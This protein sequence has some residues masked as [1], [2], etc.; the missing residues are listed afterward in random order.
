MTPERDR[1]FESGPAHREHTRVSVA[2]VGYS[3]SGKTMSLLRFAAGMAEIQGGRTVVIDSNGRRSLHYAPKRGEQPARGQTFDFDVVHLTPPFGPESW[4][5]AF[6]HALRKYKAARIIVDCMSDEWEGQGGVLDAHE[7]LLDE[8]MDRKSKSGKPDSRPD[9][10]IREAL[11]DSAWIPVK[12]A[13][14]ELRLWMWQQPVDWLLTYRAKQKID[15]SSK[16]RKELGW[17]PI[18]AQDIIYDCL[19]KC[20]LPPAGDGRP[21]WRPKEDAEKLLVKQ[22]GQFREL[23][24]AHPQVNEELGRQVAR[25]A[26]GQD[27]EINRAAAAATATSSP[28]TRPMTLAMRFDAC[29]TREAFAAL[30]KEMRAMW[31]RIPEQHAAVTAAFTSAQSR[32]KALAAS[33]APPPPID[34]DEARTISEEEAAYNRQQEEGNRDAT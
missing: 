23:F 10:K 3:G 30:D 1:T 26:A 18:G 20:L 16:E 4:R 6:E 31:K 28:T 5:A 34:D 12:R 19:F 27:I 15:R 32:M 14:L 2:V 8:M 13:H 24:A 9:W 22:P 21:D 25:W 29:N 17:Q 33:E 7:R 11:S